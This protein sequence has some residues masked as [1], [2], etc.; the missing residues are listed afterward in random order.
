MEPVISLVGRKAARLRTSNFAKRGL[1]GFVFAFA[2]ICL[3]A[4]SVKTADIPAN[5]KWVMH[6]D[7][8][9]AQSTVLGKYLSTEMGKVRHYKTIAPEDSALNLDPK[10]QVSD[11]MLYSQGS[12]LEKMVMLIYGD[13]HPNGRLSAERLRPYD[14]KGTHHRDHL[15]HSWA[16]TKK[17]GKKDKAVRMFATYHSSQLL[18]VSEQLRTIEQALDVADRRAPGISSKH[19]FAHLSSDTNAHLI[20]FAVKP[21]DFESSDTKVRTFLSAKLMRLQINE[22]D[23][24]I[25]A[26]LHCDVTDE[27]VSTRMLAGA[28]QLLSLALLATDKS[29]WG[30][31]LD[32][33]SLKRDENGLTALL[34]MPA[35]EFVA[36]LKI[37]SDKNDKTGAEK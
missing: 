6:I 15:I 4:G 26:V 36:V 14:Y 17:D 24:Q 11:V 31:I 3:D 1:I 7:W 22:V 20:E 2:A 28:K 10:R 25:K 13:F 29:G 5:A 12:Q 30:K 19:A 16:E 37:S 32:A 21:G 35:D 34:S 23:G 8:T 33:I 18:I 27:V 9:R